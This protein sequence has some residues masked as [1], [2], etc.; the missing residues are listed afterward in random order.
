MASRSSTTEKKNC[1]RREYEPLSDSKNDSD[2]GSSADTT[3]EAKTVSVSAIST[4]FPAL[5]G[6][7]TKHQQQQ[8]L[9]PYHQSLGITNSWKENWKK[10]WVKYQK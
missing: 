4:I 1:K 8:L 3:K 6:L 10:K 7:I 2:S 9:Q 5:K